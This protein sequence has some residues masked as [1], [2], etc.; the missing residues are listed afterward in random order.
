VGPSRLLSLLR[1]AVLW[2]QATDALPSEDGDGEAVRLD[3]FRCRALDAEGRHVASRTRRRRREAAA[4]GEEGS[5]EAEA[6]DRSERLLQSLPRGAVAAESGRYSHPPLR[7]GSAGGATAALYS[8]AGDDL[9]V[10]SADGLI[11]VYDARRGDLRVSPADLPFQAEDRFMLHDA[12]VLCLDAWCASGGASGGAAEARGRTLLASGCKDGLVKVWRLGSGECVRR[13]RAHEGGVAALRF[14]ADGAQLLTGGNDHVVRIFGLRAGQALREFRGH[15]SYVN[16]VAFYT[17]PQLP[18]GAGIAAGS[19]GATTLV[20]S[21]SSD[22]TVRVWDEDTLQC[23]RAFL[24][25]AATQ[26]A[27]AASAV[28]SDGGTKSGADSGGPGEDGAAQQGPR[29]AL[30]NHVLAVQPVAGTPGHLFVVGRAGTAAIVTLQ[31]RLIKAFSVADAPSSPTTNP[32]AVSNPVA[33][34]APRQTT[35]GRRCQCLG[36]AISPLA[37]YAYVLTADETLAA[38]SGAAVQCVKVFSLTT[39]DCVA[40]LEDIHSREMLGLALY[41]RPQFSGEGENS[42]L[43]TYSQDGTLKAWR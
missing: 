16:T 3:L 17:P 32:A 27:A 12:A 5:R 34:T 43:A 11:E 2:Q 40:A 13:L 15:T 36:G 7:L 9:I 38:S 30:E 1:E 24:L 10:G 33:G 18:A 8:P 42:L 29:E 21:G 19:L 41:P 6:T 22:G 4:G 35:Q 39:G 14:R 31:G 28:G 25:P 26:A 23:R 20:L 37:T